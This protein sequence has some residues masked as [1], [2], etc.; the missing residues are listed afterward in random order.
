MD[1]LSCPALV[2][3]HGAVDLC[4]QCVF[5]FVL[6][7]SVLT[8]RCNIKEEWR[9]WRSQGIRFFVWRICL[10]LA[11]IVSLGILGSATFLVLVTTGALK[12]PRE[13]IAFLVLGGLVALLVLACLI[14]LASL[15][16]LFAR[17]FVVPVM[18][19]EGVGV[20][21][22][23]RR[24]IVMLGAEKKA[25]AGYVLMKIVLVVGSTIIFGILTLIAVLLLF[26]PLSIAG[27]GAYFFAKSAGL[28][29]SFPAI[30][31]GVVLA[32]IA[33]AVMLYVIAL[34]SAP[35]MMFFQA[36]VIQFLGS[37]YPTL[38]ERISV[39]PNPVVPPS[40]SEA[41]ASPAG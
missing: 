26:I 27:A 39:P 19:L 18:A 4:L 12:A 24:V 10:G 17:D 25:Y 6:F 35:A 5:R 15:I 28:L 34:I 22:G 20:I 23:W 31:I 1:R 38:G 36:Y 11:I 21:E 8:D 32:A 30:A 9:Q 41:S 40:F 14:V 2:C 37:R 33:V 16:A 3:W 29:W 7:D 13:H